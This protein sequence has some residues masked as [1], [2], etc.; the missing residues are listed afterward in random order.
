L[1]ATSL[2]PCNGFC[3]TCARLRLRGTDECVRPHTGRANQL[4]YSEVTARGDN[5]LEH[6]LA[7]NDIRATYMEAGTSPAR[8][9]RAQHRHELRT[10]AYVTLDQ[11]N[12]G[13]VRNLTHSGI[14][15]QVVAAV[16]PRQ[17]LRVRFEL[18]YPRLQVETRA[19]VVWATFSGQCGIRFLDMPPALKQQI[20]QWIFGNLLEGISL[21][22]EHSG[23]IFAPRPESEV[24]VHAAG[25]GRASTAAEEEDDGLMVSASPVKVIALPVRRE[26]P[27]PV[28]EEEGA[29]DEMQPASADLDWLSQP[30]TGR[31][32]AWTVD[33]LV[34]L[35]SLLLFTLVFL[36]VTREAPKWPLP[37]VS[38]AALTM[39]GL[40]WAFFRYFAGGSLGTRLARIAESEGLDRERQET[41]R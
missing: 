35:A 28:I 38:G 9:A 39:A 7:D 1:L 13:I 36:S 11:A 3:R 6:S 15:V 31:T 26:P 41:F 12:G 8:R 32:L 21:H 40:Y 2:E 4:G 17:Q 5:I 30:L 19:E 34:V 22:A 37:M 29:I 16:R 20:N 24:R 33:G 14:G 25:N 27:E 23:S 10:L 18:R